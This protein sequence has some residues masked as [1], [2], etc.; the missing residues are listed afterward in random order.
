MKLYLLNHPNNTL[1]LITNKI[2]SLILHLKWNIIFL[3]F[4]K[5]HL[6][7][8]DLGVNVHFVYV[9]LK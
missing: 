1:T 9:T 2:K 7:L 4:K 3:L 6:S 5:E 8:H